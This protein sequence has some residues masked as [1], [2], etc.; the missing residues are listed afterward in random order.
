MNL[1]II[2]N[3]EKFLRNKGYSPQTIHTYTKALEQVPDS[4]NVT[5]PQLLYGDCEKKSVNKILL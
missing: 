3:F 1:E 5:E 2:H 4:W